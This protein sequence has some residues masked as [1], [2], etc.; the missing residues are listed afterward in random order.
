M[1]TRI[2]CYVAES[3]PRNNKGI[4]VDTATHNRNLQLRGGRIEYLRRSPASRKRRQKGN[5]VSNDTVRY[6]LMFCGTALARPNS[7]ST[8]KLRTRRLV[9]KGAPKEENGKCLKIFPMEVKDKTS[10]GS[11][12]MAWYEDRLA[13]WPSVVRYL[14]LARWIY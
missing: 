2:C 1:Y 9:R 14:R 3:L 7:S 6:G 5:L 12:V 13:D 4:K 10:C 11:R 8:S